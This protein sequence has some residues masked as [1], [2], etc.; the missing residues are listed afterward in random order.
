MNTWLS[1]DCVSY[2]G[3]TYSQGKTHEHLLL[4]RCFSTPMDGLISS[5]CS[6]NSWHEQLFYTST[7]MARSSTV[8]VMHHC[9]AML[10]RHCTVLH[11]PG[12]VP[13]Y[14]GTTLYVW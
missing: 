3:T 13:Q 10:H 1:K 4:T 11:R 5:P 9:F 12:I 14:H 6:T 8:I 7:I 2:G